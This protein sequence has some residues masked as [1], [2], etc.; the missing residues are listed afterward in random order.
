MNFLSFYCP[1]PIEQRPIYEYL[2]IKNSWILAW[3]TLTKAEYNSRILNTF[4]FFFILNLP[5]INNFILIVQYPLKSFFLDLSVSALELIFLFSYIGTN[6][7]YIQSRLQSPTI[8]YEESSWYDGKIWVKPV[9][10]LKQ[11]RLISYYQ[12]SPLIQRLKKILQ[13]LALSLIINMLSFFL[14]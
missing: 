5:F 12:I 9:S 4:L 14:I 6:W 13:F 10:I 11:E 8:F 2:K 3:P 1:V 7:L